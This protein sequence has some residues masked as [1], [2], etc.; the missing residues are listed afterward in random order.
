MARLQKA[1]SVVA[2]LFGLIDSA[3]L[4]TDAGERK[5]IYDQFRGLLV[6]A[7]ALDQPSSGGPNLLQ[8]V[9]SAGARTSYKIW[10]S[11]FFHGMKRA[12]TFTYL[13]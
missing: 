7:D 12:M 8:R 2:D 4:A 10:K 6:G 5:A 11:T 9:C 3:E 1:N 13:L